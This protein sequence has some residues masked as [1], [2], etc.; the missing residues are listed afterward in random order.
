MGR[1]AGAAPEGRAATER[2]QKVMARCG[3]GS[4]R[5]CED[6]IREGRVRVD[7][8]VATIGMTVDAR[9][10]RITVDGRA[11]H[12]QGIEYWLLN[13][14]A[15]TVC[16]ARDPEG[17]PTVMDGLPTRT[18]VYPVGR[19]FWNPPALGFL[20]IKGFPPWFAP[21]PVKAFRVEVLGV[22]RNDRIITTARAV[23]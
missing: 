13:K 1:E 14:R 2:I 16:T 9:Q 23:L 12:P 3:V 21:P 4:R 10:A 7:S 17:R 22:D 8:V 19:L 6:L 20:K 15:G 11:L 18:R 5:R